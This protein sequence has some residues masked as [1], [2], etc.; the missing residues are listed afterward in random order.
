MSTMISSMINLYRRHRQECEAGH[1]NRSTSGEFEERKKG[2]KKCACLIH[3]SGT[4][5][6]KFSR[7]AT[8]LMDWEQARLL[9]GQWKA[10]D[11]AIASPSS[12][13]GPASPSRVTIEKA[14][15]AYKAEL[16]DSHAKTTIRQYNFLL[17]TFEDFSLHRGYIYIDQWQPI[18]VR[19]F[20]TG[21]GVKFST[22]TTRMAIVKT[23]FRWVE[24]NGWLE[25]NPT[26]LIKVKK[27]RTERENENAP[28]V[29]F[30][31]EEL[32]R[33]FSACTV[34]PRLNRQRTTGQDLADFIAVSVYTGLRISD[35]ATFN[36]DR[37][38]ES[39]ECRIRTTKSGNPVWTWIPSWLQARIVERKAIHGP[40]IFGVHQTQDICVMTDL[41]RRKLRKL[42]KK[43]GPWPAKPM[44]HRFRH[45]FAR[46][47]LQ[48]GV[49]VPDVA[50]LLGNTE[51]IVRKHYSAWVPERQARLTQVLQDAFTDK[52]QPHV[53]QFPGRA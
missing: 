9:V 24:S 32:A 46:I 25:K 34:E 35:V 19:E 5:Q 22:A 50:E 2:W 29:P 20:R 39:G 8:G 51:A 44:P 52:P 47:L 30:T 28:R 33:M 4:L 31:D 37:L 15:L 18:D 27:T 23:F 1:P 40:L 42:W 38:I 53:L 17:R 43:C 7:K 11:G 14:I 6:G 45:T 48:K 13:P 12:A 49:S 41:W 21:W 26:R 3:A 36:A 10:W 16:A